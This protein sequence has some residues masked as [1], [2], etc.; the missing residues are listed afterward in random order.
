MGLIT[1]LLQGSILLIGTYRD[2]GP[3]AVRG[4]HQSQA[5]IYLVPAQ[6]VGT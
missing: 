6:H 5:R 1:E 2:H 3:L 4:S